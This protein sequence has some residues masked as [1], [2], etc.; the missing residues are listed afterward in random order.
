MDDQLPEMLDV[1]ERFVQAE[2]PSSDIGAT[3]K[4]ADVV[5]E[6]GTSLLG[7]EPEHIEIEGRTHLRWGSADPRVL[8]VG[9]L[10]TVWPLGTIDRL[11]FSVTD[12]IARGPGSFDMKAGLVQGFFALRS[13]GSLEGVAFLINSDEELGSPT[14]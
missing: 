5:A 13:L 3:R 9:H 2:S 8:L 14:S 1:L 12:G 10:D 4:S 7:S 6:I 11:P